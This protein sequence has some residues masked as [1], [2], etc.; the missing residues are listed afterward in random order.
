MAMTVGLMFAFFGSGTA[1]AAALPTT[2]AAACQPQHAQELLVAS[3]AAQRKG[4]A[5]T[6]NTRLDEALALLGTRYRTQATI[7]DTGM[8]LI[9]AN[10]QLHKG[11]I[12]QAAVLKRRILVERLRMCK[13]SSIPIIE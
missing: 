5:K 12:H 11:Q 13:V 7:D 4:D 1:I 9:V 10:I 8:H 2:A 6:S 3:D